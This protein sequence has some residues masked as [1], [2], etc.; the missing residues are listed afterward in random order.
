MSKTNKTPPALEFPGCTVK[1][2]RAFQPGDTVF[3]ESS[4]PLSRDAMANIHAEFKRLLPDVK[5]VVLSEGLRVASREEAAPWLDV[6]L[7]WR[8]LL[9]GVPVGSPAFVVAQ[10]MDQLL[11]DLRAGGTG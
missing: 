3:I 9:D 5:V 2:V 10:E 4:R 8:A 6:V 1:I 11:R 7:Q